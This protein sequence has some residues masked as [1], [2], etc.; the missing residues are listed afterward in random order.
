MHRGVFTRIGAVLALAV[1]CS[2]CPDD[3]SGSGSDTGNTDDVARDGIGLDLAVDRAADDSVSDGST[4][5]VAASDSTGADADDP[6]STEDVPEDD[7]AVDAGDL[8]CADIDCSLD[9]PYGLWDDLDGCPT[10]ACAPP[11]LLMEQNSVGYPDEH[12][13]F[14]LDLD[15]FIGGID[16]IIFDATWN[17]GDP[18]M[19]DSNESVTAQIGLMQL[20]EET[21]PSPEN[22]TFFFVTD[23]ETPLESRGITWTLFGVGV[24]SWEMLPTGGY[25]SIRETPEGQWEGGLLI[26]LEESSPIDPSNPRRGRVGAPFVVPALEGM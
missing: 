13:S 3:D 7:G 15:M 5:D 20:G 4:E 18:N 8:G 24:I 16:R 23:G 21:A 26:E 2:A 12:L 9:C 22:R 19:V 11:P 1:A 14:D 6:I 17:W 25:L 10:C